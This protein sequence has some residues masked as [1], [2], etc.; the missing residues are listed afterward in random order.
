M[1]PYFIYVY[2]FITVLVFGIIGNILVIMS[3]LRQ[4][5]LLKN[6]YYLLVL[7]LAINDLAVLIIDLLGLISD[8]TLLEKS[9]NY[10]FFA[11]RLCRYIYYLFQVAGIGIMLFIS[12]IRYR[13]AIH[14]LKP[15][16]SRRKMKIVCSLVYIFGLIA[17]YGPAVP[18]S[19]MYGKDIM[20]IYRKFHYIYVIFCYYI[21]PT[22]FMAVVYYKICRE[23]IQQSKRMKNLCSNPLRQRT[24][25]SSFNILTFIRNK[26][27]SFVS[28]CT[29]LCY[30][31]G[32]VPL[33]M[34]FSLYIF[35]KQD[36]LQNYVKVWY[37][38]AI[39]RVFSSY[40]V[41][42]LIYGTLD[43][44]LVCFW[45]RSSVKRKHTPHGN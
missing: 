42:P 19:F 9:L 16:L 17:G 23:L 45:K 15:A 44:K 18:L 22:S 3:I 28:F 31:V 25:N 43:K 14:P 38:A 33:T 12:V 10:Q 39:F 24:P 30:G 29:V 26:R 35:G 1:E 6:N 8:I 37:F 4:K 40:V 21:F 20:I 5:K 34:C 13:A 27:A 2:C 11:Y 41:N 36:L 7:Q 32:N